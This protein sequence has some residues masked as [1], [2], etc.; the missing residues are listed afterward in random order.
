[1]KNQIK[2][3]IPIIRESIF[4]SEEVKD[5]LLANLERMEHGDLEELKDVLFAAKYKQDDLI[6]KIA[7]HD[8]SFVPRL[9]QW[10]RTEIRKEF[11][12]YE[13]QQKGS[14]EDI[15]TDIE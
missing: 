2:K 14:A 9:K 6:K 10:K 15:L 4:L 7:S 12:R 1:M 11:H 3:L 5:S 8:E 13:K